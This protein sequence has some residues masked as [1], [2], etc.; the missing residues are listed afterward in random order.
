M[1]KHTS[2]LL[3]SGILIA[4]TVAAGAQ[5]S[6]PA[7]EDTP[8]IDENTERCIDLRRV[9]RTEVVDDRNIL[10]YM[11]GDTVYHNILPR[12]CNGLAREDRFSYK[13]SIG[14]LCDLDTIAV[15]YNDMNGLREGNRC[16]LG[17][18]H[19]ITKEDAEA[20]KEAEK[21]GPAANPLPMPE[22]EEVDDETDNPEDPES[23]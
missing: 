21:Q 13:T 5:E 18:F 19:K 3:I 2:K 17:L 1:Y 23:A 16:G 14:R 6:E 22:P 8:S 11:N 12:R 7:Q 9:R 20:Y 15:L 4:W 10:F